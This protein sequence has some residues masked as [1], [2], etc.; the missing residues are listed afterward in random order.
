MR[1]L[2]SRL[3]PTL[4]ILLSF[5]LISGCASL[6]KSWIAPEVAL[7]GL[8]IK[9][10]TLLRQVFIVTLAVRNPNDRTLPIKALTYRIKLEGNELAQGSSQLDRQIPPLGTALA[11]V[12][13]VGNLL[14]ITQQLPALAL[15]D[16][17]LDWTV[18]GTASLANGLVPL[19]YRWSG[20]IDPKALLSIAVERD[21]R[22]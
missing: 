15:K 4:S 13:V 9:E 6:T 1:R 19:P 12:E 5:A 22:L 3:A 16:R 17:P 10:L 8:R 11:D 2:M 20:Q 21:K 14:G 7:T 18:S